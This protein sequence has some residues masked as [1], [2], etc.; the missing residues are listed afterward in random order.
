MLK[1]AVLELTVSAAS[2]GDEEHLLVDLELLHADF[3]AA[4]G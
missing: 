4:A 3:L 1:Q 2:M